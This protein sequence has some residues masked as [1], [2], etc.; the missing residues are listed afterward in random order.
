L[1]GIDVSKITR[2]ALT[3][4]DVINA[5]PAALERDEVVC[6]PCLADPTLFVYRYTP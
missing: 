4:N 5:S 2:V 6:V 1:S 3:A